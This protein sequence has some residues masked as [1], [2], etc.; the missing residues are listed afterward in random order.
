M[1]RGC[2][3]IDA[4]IIVEHALDFAHQFGQAVLAEFLQNVSALADSEL[5]DICYE[6]LCAGVGLAVRP[7][8]ALLEEELSQ[9]GLVVEALH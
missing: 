8:S 1:W 7:G 4:F 9:S 3:L 6:M 5:I 2:Y